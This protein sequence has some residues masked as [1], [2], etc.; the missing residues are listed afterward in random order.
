MGE[1]GGQRRRSEGD[2]LGLLEAGL[3]ELAL[4]KSTREDDA[5]TRTEE[6]VF[7]DGVIEGLM[8]EVDH[9]GHVRSFPR[10]PQPYPHA[11]ATTRCSP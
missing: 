9:E 6:I 10:A 2:E 8:P 3:E 11:A 7:E 1:R 5:R 4:G